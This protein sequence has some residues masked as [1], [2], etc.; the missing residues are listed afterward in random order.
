MPLM[1]VFCIIKTLF[2]AMISGF[3]F[4]AYFYVY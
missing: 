4:D 2:F 3:L 1:V